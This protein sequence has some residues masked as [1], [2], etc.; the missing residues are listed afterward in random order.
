MTPTFGKV[1]DELDA[2]ASPAGVEQMRVPGGRRE[3]RLANLH[4]LVQ[5]RLW[6]QRGERYTSVMVSCEGRAMQIR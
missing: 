3:R 6:A 2:V 4:Q 5:T 1:C